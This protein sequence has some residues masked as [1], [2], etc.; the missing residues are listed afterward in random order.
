[1]NE[2][3]VLVVVLTE[4]DEVLVQSLAVSPDCDVTDVALNFINDLTSQGLIGKPISYA[5]EGG[6]TADGLS[7]KMDKFLEE[8]FPV[9]VTL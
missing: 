3:Y 9:M 5:A 6:F 2:K 7:E 4:Y 8:K 1:M